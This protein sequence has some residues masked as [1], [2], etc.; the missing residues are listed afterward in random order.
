MKDKEIIEVFQPMI[1]FLCQQK[2]LREKIKK[3]K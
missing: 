2:I 3:N 1:R